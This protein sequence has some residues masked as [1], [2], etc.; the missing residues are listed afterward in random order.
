MQTFLP[1]GQDFENTAQILDYRRLGKQ[2]VEAR[3]ILNTL[4]WR[5]GKKGWKNHVVVRMWKD[6]LNALRLYHNIMIDEWKRRGYNNTM[7]KLPIRGEI[8]FPEWINDQRL[9]YSHKAN[10]LRKKEDFYSQYNWQV[11]KECP[12][13]WPIELYGDDDWNEEWEQVVENFEGVYL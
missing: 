12:Y 7:R 10:L 3:Q 11:N 8:I 13:W 9:M 5:T 6:H 1:Y 4:T 2:R